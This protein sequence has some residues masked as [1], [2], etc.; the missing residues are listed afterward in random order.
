M[1]NKLY[2]SPKHGPDSNSLR[3]AALA[4]GW[5]VVRWP[6]W[7]LPPGVDPKAHA[8][9]YAS[10]LFAERVSQLTWL[11]FPE[12]ANDWLPN[13]SLELVQRQIQATTLSQ[14][15]EMRKRAFYKP[16]SFKVFKAGVYS[17]GSELP[18]ESEADGSTQVLI[19]EVVHWESEFRF[20]ILDGEVLTGS[21]YFR[22]GESAQVDGQWP[23]SC[24][25]MDAARDTAVKAYNTGGELPRSVVIDTGHIRGAGWAVIEANPSWGSGLY[26][27]DPDLA[28]DV[29]AQSVETKK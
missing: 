8:C 12:P 5:E 3:K 14:A 28:L 22:D 10:P 15:R 13:L 23:S 20:F 29:I 4:R 2:L 19:S 16:A 1:S 25:E 26:G 7:Q 27:S 6:N 24:E 18:N 9:L 17:C 11:E 21:V